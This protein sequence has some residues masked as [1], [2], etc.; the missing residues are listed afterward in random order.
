M[1]CHGGRVARRGTWL[2]MPARHSCIRTADFKSDRSHSKQ[3]LAAGSGLLCR[4]G[5]HCI[6]CRRNIAGACPQLRVPARRA[7]ISACRKDHGVLMKSKSLPRTASQC[8]A[9]KPMP[10]WFYY[11]PLELIARLAAQVLDYSCKKCRSATEQ[12]IR[13]HHA[14][15]EAQRKE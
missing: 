9:Q 5:K 12:V 3:Q 8:R 15:K 2:R 4:K 11:C 10:T 1:P 13:R 7:G 6:M 14:R